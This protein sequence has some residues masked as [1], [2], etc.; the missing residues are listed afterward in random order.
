LATIT[1]GVTAETNYFAN[2]WKKNRE[3]EY[4]RNSAKTFGPVPGNGAANRFGARNL[5]PGE[6][7]YLIKTDVSVRGVTLI[8]E[9][10]GRCDPAQPEPSPFLA[11]VTFPLNGFQIGGAKDLMRQLRPMQEVLAIAP[12]TVP[13]PSQPTNAPPSAQPVVQ[14]VPQPAQ[15]APLEQL[16]AA[17]P[18]VQPVAPM[19]IVLGQTIAEVDA[20]LGQ[21]DKFVDLGSKKIYIYKDMKITFVDGKVADVE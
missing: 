12:R 3:I 7:L 20:I 15:Q 9:T 19:K 5:M 21:P 10:C 18:D 8:V 2:T 16:P 13:V 1:F 11:G 4:D 6:R 17:S 14:M